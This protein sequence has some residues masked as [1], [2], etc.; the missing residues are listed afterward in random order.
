M[1]VIKEF[2]LVQVVGNLAFSSN[3]KLQIQF[4][5]SCPSIVD[6][7]GQRMLFQIEYCMIL[8]TV[9]WHDVRH[10]NPL[11]PLQPFRQSK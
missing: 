10:L 9:C 6:W 4:L 2:R 1:V 7:I 3:L 8:S 5:C 11:L